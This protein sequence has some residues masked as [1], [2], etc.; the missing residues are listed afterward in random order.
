MSLFC[1]GPWVHMHLN[2]DVLPKFEALMASQRM[3]FYASAFAARARLLGNSDLSTVVGINPPC[4]PCGDAPAPT[5]Q[6][7]LDRHIHPHVAFNLQDETNETPW[8]LPEEV[9]ETTEILINEDRY[10]GQVDSL[11]RLL[12]PSVPVYGFWLVLLKRANLD[13]LN[14]LREH[15]AALTSGQPFKTLSPSAKKEIGATL[16]SEGLVDYIDRKQVPVMIDFRTGDVWMGNAGKAFVDGLGYLLLGALGAKVEPMQCMPGSNPGWVETALTAFHDRDINKLEREEALQQ[17]LEAA[18]AP[19]EVDESADPSQEGTDEDNH[20][21]I[22]DIATFASDTGASVSVQPSAC[23]ILPGARKVSVSAGDSV[24]A[25]AVLALE[26]K[27]TIAAARTSYMWK[28]GECSA[29]AA[30]D[31]TSEL[32]ACIFKGLEVDFAE[33]AHQFLEQDVVGGLMSLENLSTPGSV[34]R[35]NRYWY[36]YLLALRECERVIFSTAC[37]AM[38]LEPISPSVSRGPSEQATPAEETVVQ[39]AVT[40]AKKTMS[41]ALQP[42]ESL[43]ITTP[44]GSTTIGAAVVETEIG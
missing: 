15:A 32:G 18:P 20:Y 11:F 26:P 31:M 10:W 2:P 14:A 25:L 37:E 28:I 12:D 27:A 40:K 8:I 42:G 17:T 43:T 23:I 33:G 44:K 24:D 34:G 7:Y 16:V 9:E 30:V 4:W 36:R 29:K 1:K 21:I 6:T 38:D 19:A 5:S 13:D 41:D 35:V 22:H 3:L 39:Q